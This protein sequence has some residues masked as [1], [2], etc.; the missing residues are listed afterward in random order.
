MSG[1]SSYYGDHPLAGAVPLLKRHVLL[2]GA[3]GVGE[4]LVGAALCSLTGWSFVEIERVVEHDS[5]HT[6][7]RLMVR[8]G[9][10]MVSARCWAHLARVFARRPPCVVAVPAVV[11]AP[12]PR[13]R[14][15]LEHAD[16]HFIT[17]PVEEQVEWLEQRSARDDG[18]LGWFPAGVEG[19]PSVEVLHQACAPVARVATACHAVRP[20]S[21]L[22][23]A[24]SLMQTLTTG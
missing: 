2:A 9:E 1:P 15:A 18:K 23:T 3:P 19:P 16:L 7:A 5:R 20:A 17:A 6:I 24:R 11:L 12:G 4:G 10:A 14:H 21:H 8:E 13:L 22:R